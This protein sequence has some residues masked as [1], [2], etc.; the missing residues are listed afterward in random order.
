[1]VAQV[2]AGAVYRDHPVGQP[3]RSAGV[4]Q[5]QHPVDPGQ[6]GPPRANRANRGQHPVDP[7]LDT[8]RGAAPGQPGR[9]GQRLVD[10]V[11][12]TAPGA[13]P[14]QPG[15]PDRPGPPRADRQAQAQG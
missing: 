9:P 5:G 14:G 13:A 7:V 6:W 8:A 12:D 4:D 2:C 1:M 3:T 11:L 15:Q 10:P